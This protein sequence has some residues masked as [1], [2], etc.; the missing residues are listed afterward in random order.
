MRRTLRNLR[1]I[2]ETSLRRRPA[3][4]SCVVVSGAMVSRTA[5]AGAIA[6]SS[7]KAMGLAAPRPRRPRGREGGV[8]AF[9]AENA[10][11][12][13]LIPM[14]SEAPPDRHPIAGLRSRP[15]R[16]SGNGRPLRS[17]VLRQLCRLSAGRPGD[18][19]RSAA[20]DRPEVR[21]GKQLRRVQR[22]R[23]SESPLRVKVASS[24]GLVAGMRELSTGAKAKTGRGH[25]HLLGNPSPKAA[26]TERQAL[27]H[28]PSE[29]C[30]RP[31]GM[32][33]RRAVFTNYLCGA[34]IPWQAQG[35]RSELALFSTLPAKPSDG[36]NIT[37]I[38]RG[39][40]ACPAARGLRPRPRT[41]SLTKKVPNPRS[42][43]ETP[44]CD[45]LSPMVCKTQSR[46]AEDSA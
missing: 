45:S 2:G 31:R 29:T 46:I 16:R 12:G 20:R 11:T 42:F 39:I 5:P 6:K 3:R 14:K 8:G 44:N 36:L 32:P 27:S 33:L 34:A 15:S 26:D 4:R 7:T 24:L 41:L 25:G 22:A 30:R 21:P 35:A 43:T 17:A 13:G 18:D 9:S 23:A 10:G 19:G 37:V 40:D 28:P 38:R 1:I